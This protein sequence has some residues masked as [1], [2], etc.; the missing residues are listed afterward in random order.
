MCT[1]TPTEGGD[2]KPFVKHKG[3]PTNQHGRGY[4]NNYQNITSR[5]GTLLRADP[6]LRG[7]IFKSKRNQSEQVVNFTTANDIIKRQAG[8]EYAQLVL[9]SLKKE[10]ES[11]PEEPAAVIKG[12]GTITKIE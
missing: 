4:N 10:V 9:E 1:K 11:G 6:D 12:D 3:Q 8:T 2:K 7:H 5:K